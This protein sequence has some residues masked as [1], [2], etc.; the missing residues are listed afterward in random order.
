MPAKTRVHRSYSTSNTSDYSI[1]WDFAHYQLRDLPNMIV[2]CS[3]CHTS[4]SVSPIDVDP[5]NSIHD[6]RVLSK[7]EGQELR[8]LAIYPTPPKRRKIAP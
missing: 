4:D 7:S 1:A 5:I 8:S 6:S 3:E 2:L